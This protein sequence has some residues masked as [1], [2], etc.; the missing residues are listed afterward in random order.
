MFM[1]RTTFVLVTGMVAFAAALA[2]S[3]YAATG[4]LLPFDRAFSGELQHLDGGRFYEPLANLLALGIIEYTLLFGAAA[5]ACRVGDRAL[6]FSVVL[7]LAARA[8][9]T[10]LKELIDRPRPDA[11]DMLI[12][13]PADGLGFPSGHSSTVVLVYGYAAFVAMRYASARVAA[14]LGALALAVVLL[15]GW[16]RVYDGA[17]WPSDVLGG[18]ATGATLLILAVSAPPVAMQL[19]HRLRHAAVGHSE[20][21]GLG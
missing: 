1:P 5:Y 11:S 2:L 14:V 16:D 18:Y 4:S 19:W 9:N 20:M 15:I 13:D 12:R 7:V 17:H 10:P 8:L 21:R 6:A 3:L